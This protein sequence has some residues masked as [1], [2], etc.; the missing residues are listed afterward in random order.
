LVRVRP[1]R[2]V[3]YYSYVGRTDIAKLAEL[4]RKSNA[5]RLARP[6]RK[7]DH[8]QL[9]AVEIG[10]LDA[11]VGISNPPPELLP[12]ICRDQS[13]A[14]MRTAALLPRVRI[15]ASEVTAMGDGL[16]RVDV[17]V[18]NDGYLGTCGLPSGKNLPFNEPLWAEA[19]PQGGLSL[20]TTSEARQ[21]LGHLEGWG[22][23]RGSGAGSFWF[24]RSRGS[25][26]RRVARFVVRG[27]G[28]LE[29]RI[30]SCRIGEL[31]CRVEVP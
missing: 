14:F 21:E 15:L 30:G 11:R 19:E 10:G 7:F 22:R 9:G 28:V 13:A 8:P 5:G 27:K 16:A 29:V 25:D 2:F 24:Q 12:T 18:E 26:H 4:D 17:T 20:A 31:L 1:K 3:D 6:W 23:G